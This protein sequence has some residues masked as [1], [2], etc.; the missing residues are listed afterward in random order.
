[1]KFAYL[2][3]KMALVKL[4]INFDVLR[5]PKTPDFLEYSEGIVR[6]PKGG[7]HVALKKRN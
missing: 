6:A 3:M 7:L 1:M 5:S 4:L 2:E